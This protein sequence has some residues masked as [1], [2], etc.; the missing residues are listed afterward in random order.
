MT[1]KNDPINP[2]HYKTNSGI[3]CIDITKHFTYT[4]GNAIKYAWR[5]GKKDNLLQDLEKCLWYLN[6]TIEQGYDCVSAYERGFIIASRKVS[7]LD[8]KDFNNYPRQ[9]DI[10]KNL[11]ANSLDLAKL[12]LEKT[13]K[14]LKY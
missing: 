7:K 13:I 5:A 6:V 8:P 9:W 14:E 2:N 1:V 3:E 10:L 12:K 4:L 11:I